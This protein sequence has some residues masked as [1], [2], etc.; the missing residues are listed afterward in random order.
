MPHWTASPGRFVEY[1]IRC[2]RSCAGLE[3]RL[4]TCAQGLDTEDGR[5]G[6]L[7][8]AASVDCKMQECMTTLAGRFV[9][10]LAGLGTNQCMISRIAVAVDAQSRSDQN[11]HRHTEWWVYIECTPE[12]IQPHQDMNA[13]LVAIQEVGEAATEAKAVVTR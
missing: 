9:A 2:P 6:E 5:S 13:A 4:S 3:T 10:A 1:N 11:H 8:C 12:H 7:C